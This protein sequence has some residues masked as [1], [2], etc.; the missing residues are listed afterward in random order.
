MLKQSKKCIILGLCIIHGIVSPYPLNKSGQHI[1][2]KAESIEIQEAREETDKKQEKKP[3]ILSSWR[4][5]ITFNW[6]ALTKTDMWNIS[7]SLATVMGSG[8]LYHYITKNDRNIGGGNTYNANA[9]PNLNNLNNND[10]QDDIMGM[11]DDI[12]PQA[13][14]NLEKHPILIHPTVALE[15]PVALT[16]QKIDDGLTYP[17]TDDELT[18]LE[19]GQLTYQE[20]DDELVYPEVPSVSSTCSVNNFSE[21]DIFLPKDV[22]H[23]IALNMI[24]DFLPSLEKS[25]IKEELPINERDKRNGV[26]L[27]TNISPDGTRIVSVISGYN[28]K[29]WNVYNQVFHILKGHTNII[30]ALAISQNNAYVVTGS[31]DNTVKIWGMY[32]GQLKHTCE[33]ETPIKA[34]FIHNDNTFTTCSQGMVVKKWN[35]ETGKL[36]QT[37]AGYTS[38]SNAMLM[39]RPIEIYCKHTKDTIEL[40]DRKTSNLLHAFEQK[41]LVAVYA[42]AKSQDNKYA[43]L[44][45]SDATV[46]IIPLQENLYEEKHNALRWIQHHIVPQQAHLIMRAFAATQNKEAFVINSTTHDALVW[47]TFPD[48]VRYYL[49]SCLNVKLI[50]KDF[51]LA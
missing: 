44:G 38:Y 42:M 34:I 27:S 25:P 19:T 24:S 17:G 1:H 43:I 36:L 30:S 39:Y 13:E 21:D 35:I 4:K 50:L 48:Y 23:V 14:T 7:K 15:Y 41:T 28:I 6:Q 26:L 47:V 16:Y 33:H 12:V 2:S 10:M 49:R 31:C 3:T 45:L 5:V 11:Q 22:Q 8:L 32:S 9:Y 51:V 46:K 37:L 18:N 29:I 20:T 40:I